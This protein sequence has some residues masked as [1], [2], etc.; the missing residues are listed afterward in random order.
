M[1]K[2]HTLFFSRRASILAGL[3]TVSAS[4]RVRAGLMTAALLSSAGHA[5]AQNS[6]FG[7]VAD[8]VTGQFSNFG[9]L[10]GGAASLLGLGFCL[11]SVAKFKGYSANPQDPNN[12]LTTAV[13]LLA[14][15]V[16]LIA[17]PAFMGVGV[18]SLFGEGASTGD[19]SG[20]NLG[21]L[22]GG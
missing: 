17:L 13:G 11:L 3:S 6:N 1:K 19:L 21:P 14:A 22:S 10:L 2:N 4:S 18:N 5:L 9:A 7:G 12:K 16:A 15:G 8:T 20:T